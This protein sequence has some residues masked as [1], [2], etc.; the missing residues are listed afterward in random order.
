MCTCKVLRECDIEKGMIVTVLQMKKTND[1][2]YRGD[3]F[4]V[5]GFEYP[6]VKVLTEDSIR[7]RKWYQTFDLRRYDLMQL[8]E[9]FW[10]PKFD[11][12]D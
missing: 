11:E 12:Q 1:G 4:K 6:Y 3:A 7:G 10:T 5:V 2:S 9:E 8:P